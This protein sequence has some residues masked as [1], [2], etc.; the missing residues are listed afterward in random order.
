M[1][2]ILF[3]SE[4]YARTDGFC[5]EIMCE[6]IDTERQCNVAASVLGLP[7]VSQT[8]NYGRLPGCFF[9]GPTQ[10]V[11]FNNN[12]QDTTDWSDTDS[13]CYCKGIDIYIAMAKKIIE[14][15]FAFAGVENVSIFCF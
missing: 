3:C 8:H 1:D 10:Q 5:A 12:L 7:A 11:E 6:I 2:I 14:Y 9:Y 13:L 4:V 15:T